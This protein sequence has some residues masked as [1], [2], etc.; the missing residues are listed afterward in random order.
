MHPWIRL[1]QVMEQEVVVH[2]KLLQAI[3]KMRNSLLD[4]D[5]KAVEKQIKIQGLCKEQIIKLEVD[6]MKICQELE[7]L[8]HIDGQRVLSEIIVYAPDD[9]QVLFDELREK[10]LVILNEIKIEVRVL[11]YV[12]RTV[13]H[14][15][16][17]II[18]IYTASSSHYYTANGSKKKP[19]VNLYSATA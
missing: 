7:Q 5:L 17:D 12:L 2:K 14:Y 4:R 18:E 19:A 6:R 3:K 16:D 1:K 8:Y 10:F 13:I 9:F 15:I 11:R